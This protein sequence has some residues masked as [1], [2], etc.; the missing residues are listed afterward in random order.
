MKALPRVPAVFGAAAAVFETARHGSAGVS[1]SGDFF[2]QSEEGSPTKRV[3][4][5]TLS[6]F[7]RSPWIGEGDA[8]Q[9]AASGIRSGS[10]I[11]RRYVEGAG[12]IA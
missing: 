11:D 6:D 5:S 2:Q 12:G 8:S 9:V 3:N 7:V 4:E 1:L 10:Y